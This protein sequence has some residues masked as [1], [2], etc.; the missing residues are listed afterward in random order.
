MAIFHIREWWLWS[1]KRM[2]VGRGLLGRITV[3]GGWWFKMAKAVRSK[4]SSKNLQKTL[5]A[6]C[7]K[8]NTRLNSTSENASNS[9]SGKKDLFVHPHT[10][11]PCISS[12]RSGKRDW[13]HFRLEKCCPH[14]QWLPKWVYFSVLLKRAQ[15]GLHQTAPTP[16]GRASVQR[17]APDNKVI[18][19]KLWFNQIVTF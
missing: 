19:K 18:W 1:A 15:R 4:S 9:Y 13:S 12:S 3:E 8:D 11:E 17:A 5:H 10:P 2:C 14:V 7:I 16:P 6:E